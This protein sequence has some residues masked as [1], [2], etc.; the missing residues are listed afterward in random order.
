[1]VRGRRLAEEAR[2]DRASASSVVTL[3]RTPRSGES[4]PQL[5]GEMPGV[6]VS[7]LGGLGSLAL[8][9]LRGST[10]EQV[11]VYLDGVPLNAAVGGGV[12]LSTL[13]LGDVERIEVYRGMSP[14]AFGS[15]ALGGIVSI[16]TRAP[17]TTAA[18]A[19]V[20]MGSFGTVQG[21]AAASWAGERLKAYAGAHWQRSDGDFLYPSNNG[22]AF[23]PSD[24]RDVPRRNNGFSQIDGTARLTVPLA[25]DRELAL[26]GSL[27]SREQGLPGYGVFFTRE[28]S[29]GSLRSLASVAY[30]SRDDLGDGGRLQGTAYFL[31]TETRFRDRLSEIAYGPAST[32]DRTRALG[33]SW[34]AQKTLGPV[35]VGAVL[36]GRWEGFRPSDTEQDPP[37]GPPATRLAGA[38]GL[39]A[40]TSIAPA[41]LEITPSVRVEMARDV[42][43]GRTLFQDFVPASPPRHHLQ[44]LA[45]L[46]LVQWP[47]SWLALKANGGRY[48]RLAN[49]TELYGDSGFVLGNPDLR[50]EAGWNADLGAT[51][52]W[53]G[54]RLK[55]RGETFLFG[56]TVR[57]LIQY[58]QGAG[59]V[60]RARNIAR[61]RVVGVENSAQLE[62]GR[63][64]R[65][66]GQGTWTDG[67]ERTARAAS[68]R[69][70][71]LRPVLRGYL[72]P[73][74]R[75]L[76]LPF[77][78][79]AGVY[80]ELDATGGNYLDPANLVRMPARL[81][82]GAGLA[83]TTPLERARLVVSA[84]NLTDSR[85]S[86]LAGYP[87]PGR[88]FFAT[89][90]LFTNPRSQP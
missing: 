12:D 89:L 23:D 86:D 45:R 15:S 3:D 16:S 18:Q 54:D 79:G 55:L 88:A 78:F 30:R 68:A 32:R 46:S 70:L 27:F 19:E 38:A 40:I 77:G 62:F 83:I 48:V 7:R 72:R 35:R 17:D 63:H 2:E 60:Q 61:A 10:W 11:L 84:Q 71:P 14:I 1:V 47:A 64:I 75:A 4:V 58:E 56:S 13:P 9:S 21:G 44:P 85:I 76:P 20:G 33:S 82:V 5:L 50:P 34:H 41:R 37:L 52:H 57:D 43:A 53:R 73:E 25:G 80:G 6:T 42:V 67:R 8:V 28:V 74:L 36:D 29:L 24:D 49:F 66:L 59:G 81:L 65:L 87:L 26:L 39:E 69:L 22:T 31:F 51:V 90:S